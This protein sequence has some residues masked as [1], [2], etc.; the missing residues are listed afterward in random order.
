MKRVVP[1]NKRLTT[2]LF[3]ALFT[4]TIFSSLISPKPFGEAQTGVLTDSTFDASADSTA[5]RAASDA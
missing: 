2:L 1:F 4:G 3:I 5:L